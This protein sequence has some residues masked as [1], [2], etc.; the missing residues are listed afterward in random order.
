MTHSAWTPKGRICATLLIAGLASLATAILASTLGRD[1]TAD[2]FFYIW[3]GLW[4][5]SGLISALV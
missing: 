3:L 5:L 1:R 2:W 4:V